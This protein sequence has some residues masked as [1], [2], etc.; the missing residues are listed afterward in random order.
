MNKN[1]KGVY[2]SF[3]YKSPSVCIYLYIEDIIVETSI[4][5]INLYF[6]W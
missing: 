5:C 1:M 4:H 2:T 6:D 3:D